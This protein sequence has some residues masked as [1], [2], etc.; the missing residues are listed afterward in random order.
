VAKPSTLKNIVA[1]DRIRKEK[2]RSQIMASG[3]KSRT[4]KSLSVRTAPMRKGEAGDSN[5]KKKE[6]ENNKG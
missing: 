6:M 3:A 4:K 5:S 2:P 1:A